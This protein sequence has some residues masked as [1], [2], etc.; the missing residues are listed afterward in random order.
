MGFSN[1]KKNIKNKNSKAL[2]LIVCR[3]E[4][5]LNRVIS[6]FSYRLWLDLRSFHYD[7]IPQFALGSKWETA[8]NCDV[9]LGELHR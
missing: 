6:S 2:E 4:K 9:A 8:T 1:T 5:K 7:A 3:K